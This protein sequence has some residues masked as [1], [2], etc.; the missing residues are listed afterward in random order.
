MELFYNGTRASDHVESLITTLDDV[1]PPNHQKDKKRQSNVT[2]L[3]TNVAVLINI[4][5]VLTDIDA[6]LTS[7]RHPV[8]FRTALQ[9]LFM[10]LWRFKGNHRG[11]SRSFLS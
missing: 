6:V 9:I 3:S 1:P 11:R 4:A 10:A 2:V 7:G 5:F 8:P